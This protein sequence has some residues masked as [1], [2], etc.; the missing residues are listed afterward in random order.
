MFQYN[1]YLNIFISLCMFEIKHQKY[2]SILICGDEFHFF[3][4]VRE[5]SK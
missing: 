1:L 5:F 4:P 2:D 3:K